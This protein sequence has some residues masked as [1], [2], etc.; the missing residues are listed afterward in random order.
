MRLREKDL[1]KRFLLCFGA[2][3]QPLKGT[4]YISKSINAVWASLCQPLRC[5]IMSNNAGNESRAAFKEIV[6]G[7]PPF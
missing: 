5:R 7:F 3:I 6:L 4:I 2:K 1:G